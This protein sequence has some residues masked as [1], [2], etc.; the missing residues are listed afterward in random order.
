MVH[1]KM[2]KNNKSSFTH[3][4]VTAYLYEFLLWNTKEDILKQK[5]WGK[6]GQISQ[7]GEKT[8]TPLILIVGL[9][10]EN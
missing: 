6:L 1:P 9:Q 4:H 10:G 5:K 8:W 3:P 7:W 2:K